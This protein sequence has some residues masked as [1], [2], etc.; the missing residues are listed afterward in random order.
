MIGPVVFAPRTQT[1]AT[2]I[3][4]CTFKDFDEYWFISRARHTMLA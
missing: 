3:N 4:E 2:E 1:Y